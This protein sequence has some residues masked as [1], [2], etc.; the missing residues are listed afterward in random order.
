MEKITPFDIP[1]L[2]NEICQYLSLKDLARCVQV[3]KAWSDWF[4]PALWRDLDCHIRLP[5]VYLDTFARYQEHVK[6]MR[7]IIMK[8]AGSVFAQ[9]RC[10]NLQRL[11]F[12]QDEEYKDVR[13]SQLP[14]LR[15][16]EKMPT[17]RHLQIVLALDHDNTYKYW[18]RALEA[19]P[20]LESLGLKFEE[21]VDGWVIQRMLHLC[22]G[23]QC[24]SVGLM[25]YQRGVQAKG[26]REY[27]D[28]KATVETMPE[29]QLRELSFDQSK[30]WWEENIFQA[31]LERCPRLERLSLG[32]TDDRMLFQHL[33]KT[34]KEN[35]LSALR[36]LRMA[37]L[38]RADLN[39]LLIEVL[40]HISCG[41]ESFDCDELVGDDGDDDNPVVQTLI[42]YHSH[43][44]TRLD[45]HESRLSFGTFVNLMVGLPCLQNFAA[46][47]IDGTTD[48]KKDILLNRHWECLGLRSLQLSLRSWRHYATSGDRW[49]E[50]AEKRTLDYVLSEVAKLTS[51]RELR[52]RCYSIDLYNKS[53]GYLEQLAGLKQLEILGINS[54]EH[55]TLGED[56]AQWMVD[57]WPKLLQVYEH[58]APAVFKETLLKGRPLVEFFKVPSSY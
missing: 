20:H 31:L 44:L 54:T 45:L 21:S 58:G 35:K 48:G 50:S 52:I 14:V 47:I 30:F 43:S 10:T 19:M 5:Y 7:N 13:R 16:L 11:E 51:L 40:S 38:Y 55:Y 37:I 33:V 42:K 39:S 1:L 17:L 29:M 32:W 25:G 26:L 6:T 49:M 53:R 9:V 36:H 8:Q 57:N 22:H 12:M 3:S 34:L 15:S 4:S 56:E 2:N 46:V 28:A 41:L 18:I 27:K 23:L 24:L